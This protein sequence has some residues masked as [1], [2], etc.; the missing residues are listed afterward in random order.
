M[1][2]G[3]MTM[4]DMIKFE[5]ANEAGKPSQASQS[6]LQNLSTAT[7]SSHQQADEDQHLVQCRSCGKPMI[8]IVQRVTKRTTSSTSLGLNPKRHVKRQHRWSNTVLHKLCNIS[9]VCTVSS[10]K[11]D[12][13][14]VI[15]AY[16]IWQGKMVGSEYSRRHH[17]QLISPP[18]LTQNNMRSCFNTRTGQIT[19]AL[20]TD[21][22]FQIVLV[23]IKAV[24]MLS[25]KKL[26]QTL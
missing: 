2:D 16:L 26:N 14:A 25:F 7:L 15:S 23:G 19:I 5:E 8:S 3:A 20:M 10:Y 12:Q 1:E 17:R 6:T 21:T 11:T 24:V 13:R 18:A 9:V 4:E 22:G